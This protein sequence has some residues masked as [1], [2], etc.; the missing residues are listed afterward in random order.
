M[1]YLKYLLIAVVAINYSCSEFL[2]I[3]PKGEIVN[4]EMFN[5]EEGFEDAIYGVYSTLS[6]EA[7]F[8][9]MLGYHFSD[10]AAQYFYSSFTGDFTRQIAVYDYRHADSRKIVDSIWNTLYQ[11][12]SYTNNILENLAKKEEKSM[13]LYKLYKG[14]CLALRAFMHFEVVRYF[15]ESYTNNKNGRGVPYRT[16]YDFAVY[17]YETVEV[18]YNKIIADLL[19]AERLISENGEYFGP[20]AVNESSFTY[21][22]FIHL[23]LHAVQA[24]LA[25]AYW[26]MG[27]LEK[28]KDYALSVINS[29]KFELEAM[30]D[31]GDMVGGVLSYKETIFGVYSRTKF[32]ESTRRDLYYSGGNTLVVK[33]D[34]NEFYELEREGFDY[35]L[36][37][38][39]KTVG[40]FG[41][42]GLR[43]L[44]IV[45]M[46]S[47]RQLQRPFPKIS[48]INIIRLPEMYYIV[49]EYYL[50]MD[51]Q[52]NAKKYIDKVLVSRGLTGYAARE[53][54]AL[55]IDKLNIERRK[56]YVAEGQYFHVMKRY[57]LSGYDLTSDQT[58]SPSDGIYILPIPI[59]EDEHHVNGK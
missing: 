1:K 18:T 40:D 26:S 6:Q 31:I 16:K 59:K 49:S 4:D 32:N 21:D 3:N 58:F 52:P 30:T 9:E 41:A 53:G 7:L 24:L 37:N 28:A 48:G 11:N 19:E 43:C 8:G 39:F 51:D 46:F 54:F 2:N 10:V 15:S 33:E 34:Y 56:E 5:S 38:W 20:P 22:R 57:N 42:E 50:L 23:N 45:D 14:E 29:G 47:V 17:P 27:N 36:E 25:R 12:I 44:K 55:S 13:K 35:R